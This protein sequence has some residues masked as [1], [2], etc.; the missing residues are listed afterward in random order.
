MHLVPGRVLPTLQIGTK[1]NLSSIRAKEADTVHPIYL[2]LIIIMCTSMMVDLFNKVLKIP[3]HV[4]HP[5][6]PPSSVIHSDMVYDPEHTT[7]L[8]QRE[9]QTLWTIISS[10]ECYI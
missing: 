1:F 4:L 7:A 6:L 8:Y 5:L 10:S 3:I 2:I 9:P